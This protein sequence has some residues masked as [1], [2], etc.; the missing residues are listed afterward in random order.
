MFKVVNYAE[1]KN[2]NPKRAEGTCRWAFRS[3]EYIR[4]WESNCNDL[5]WVSADLGCGKSVLARS[6]IDDYSE[7]SRLNLFSQQSD[8]LTYAI[9]TW[10]K[11]GGTLRQEVDELW[12]I[13][14]AATSAEISCKTIC[15][16]D[17]IDECRETD[18]RR[19]IDKL[20]AFHR[21]PSS[22]TEE[23]CLKFLV[24]SRPYDHI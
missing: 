17:A 23:T 4:W 20:Q 14:M 7:T 12:R 18:Q 16:F 5:L 19:L 3:S 21:Q 24:T 6:I 1:Q 8:L 13:L 2:I 22:S 11:N 15:I 9:S 10:E